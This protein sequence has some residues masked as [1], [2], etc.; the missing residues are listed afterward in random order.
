[1]LTLRWLFFFL[2]LQGIFACVKLGS[3]L[4]LCVPLFTQLADLT[5][6]P[7]LPSSIPS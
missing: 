5:G 4:A 1:M 7:P 6:V 3:G 2:N